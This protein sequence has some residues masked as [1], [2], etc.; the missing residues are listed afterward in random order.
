MHGTER[1]RSVYMKMENSKH[2][3]LV[4]GSGH[5][6]WC[7]Y[8]LATLLS[9]TGHNVTTLDLPASGINQTQQQQLHSFSDYAE[10]LFEFL[11]SLPPEEKVILVGHSM[12][13]PVISIAMEMFPEKIAAAVFATAFMPGY[14][15]FKPIQLV[16]RTVVSDSQFINDQGVDNPPSAMIFGPKRLATKLYQLSPPED[17]TLALSLVRIFPL[18]KE[19]IKLSKEKYGSVPRVF[20]VSDQDLSIEEDAQMW[21]IEN[22]PPNEVKVINGADHMVMLLGNMLNYLVLVYLYTCIVDE[23]YDRITFHKIKSP[24]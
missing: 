16:E 5:G 3:V 21:M 14:C 19:D 10:P 7:W 4:H 13:G 6:A 2:F 18:F 1:D 9:S 24:Y 17:L 8:K 23:K 20:I 15:L 11:G 12:G 22:N